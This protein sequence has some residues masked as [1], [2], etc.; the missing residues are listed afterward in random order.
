MTKTIAWVLP[1][2]NRLARRQLRTAVVLLLVD[3]AYYRREQISEAFPAADQARRIG[4]SA[5]KQRD[6]K[7]LAALMVVMSSDWDER[8]WEVVRC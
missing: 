8:P 5:F 4:H 3:Q 7:V 1:P 2:M 6:T